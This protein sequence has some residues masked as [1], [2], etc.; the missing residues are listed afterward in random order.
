MFRYVFV[1]GGGFTTW[2]RNIARPAR[3]AVQRVV[4]RGVFMGK[5]VAT[6]RGTIKKAFSADDD[7]LCG[8]ALKIKEKMMAAKAAR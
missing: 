6:T 4:P 2:T 1:F 7:P 3:P 5:R 8:S